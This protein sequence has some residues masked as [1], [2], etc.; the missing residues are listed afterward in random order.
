MSKISHTL[1]TIGAAA[2]SIHMAMAD[3]ELEP[4]LVTAS[5]TAVEA[6]ETGSSVSVIT[7]AQL[8]Q[9]GT[10]LVA[11]VLRELPGVAV[12]RSG[13]LGTLTQ[14][15]MR[16]SESDK[17]LVLI[18]GIEVNDP[19]AGSF[20]DFAHLLASD[21]DRMEVLR[22][23]QSALWGSD[24][25]GG[26]I[27]IST[28]RGSGPARARGAAEGGSFSTY[29]LNG[30]V[31]GGGD[32]YHFSANAEYQDTDGANIARQGTEDDGYDNLTLSLRGGVDINDSVDV[33][34]SVRRTSASTAS[35]PAPS[36]LPEDGDVERESD[37]TYGRLQGTAATL[38][39]AWEHI[40]GVA[41]TDT[42]NDDLS[43]GARTGSVDGEKLRL[44]YQSN[45][46]FDTTSAQ[47]TVTVLV[48]NEQEDFR[49]RGAAGQFGNPNQDQSFTNTGFVGEYR[50][51][52]WDQFFP[53]ASIR[54]D[55][56]D[57]FD[58][59][60][61]WRVTAAWV[62]PGSKIR[63]HGSYGTGVKNPT[64]FD[65]FGFTPDTFTGNPDLRP[66]E[67]KGGDIG[68]EVPL[69]R[70][71]LIVDLTYFRQ[72]LEDEINGFFFDPS[73]GEFGG[74]TAMNLSGESKREGLEFSLKAHP[75]DSLTL[76]G[77]F[78]YT[79]STEPDPAT[80]E[81]IREVRRPARMFALNTNYRFAN[82]RANINLG[83]EHNS[84]QGD[85]DFRS[86]PAQIATLDEFTL[87]NIAGSYAINDYA[88]AFVRVEN[89][90]DEDY[91]EILGFETPGAAAY[92]GV[93]IR[94]QKTED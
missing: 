69:L 34:A 71:R 30:G 37:F 4:V 38:D 23:P 93:R 5:R 91:E 85:F 60:M 39:D 28:R 57:E 7:R 25:I 72:E 70:K 35:D 47:H 89:A 54:H 48:E 6:G 15:R 88:T 8:E 21:I 74:F 18:D 63:L 61:T 87:V 65:R 19:G 83:I 20:F 64:F 77:S 68:I 2:V 42:T 76:G 9:R 58:D 36:G 59:A 29:G 82:N 11:D 56:N 31:S 40:I 52:L 50:A 45:I 41:L 12:S 49:Q 55:D 84:R 22:G 24:A 51:A 26:V 10:R 79:D 43:D 14:V 80:G 94:G 53:S 67:S 46:Y 13:G 75:T 73:I 3:T 44:D 33:A 66:E 92:A 16:G 17:V 1:W 81:R 27:S 32:G 62:H 78:T 86:F 90:L